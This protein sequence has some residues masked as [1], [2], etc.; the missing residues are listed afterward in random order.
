MPF[1]E[2]VGIW[3][4][5]PESGIPKDETFR[6]YTFKE[7]GAFICHTARSNKQVQLLEGTFKLDK[8]KV[9]FFYGKGKFTSSYHYRLDGDWLLFK[10]E[11]LEMRLR[12]HIG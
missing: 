8:E 9:R 2:I 10:N 6:Q 12:K 4:A 3:D 11:H 1:S 5:F 7:N